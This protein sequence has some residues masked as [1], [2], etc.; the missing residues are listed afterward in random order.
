[1]VMKRGHELL[2]IQNI[3]HEDKSKHHEIRIY[4]SY[5]EYVV[6]LTC[7]NIG[8]LFLAIIL[9]GNNFKINN[10]SVKYNLFL[11]LIFNFKILTY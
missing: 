11:L 5:V 10:F 4:E 6:C 3:L 7:N 9:L 2:K 8:S 1:M